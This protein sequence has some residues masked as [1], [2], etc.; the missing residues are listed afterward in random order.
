MAILTV[1]SNKGTYRLE[2]LDCASCAGKI[3]DR[4]RRELDP[5]ANISFATL[6]LTI[7]AKHE[8]AAK[9]IIKS[10]EPGI[11]VLDAKTGNFTAKAVEGCE[12][13]HCHDHDHSHGHTHRGTIDLWPLVGA[14]L[15]FV[16]GLIFQRR[17]AQTTYG[18]GEYLVFIP[19]YLLVGRGVI[20]A[21]VRNALRGQIFDENF[22]MTVATIGAFAIGNFPEAVGVMLF[23]YVGELLQD[24]AV[25]RSR[26]S[27]QEL[28]DIRPDI[29]HLMRGADSVDVNPSEVQIGDTILVRPGERI[30][31]D[32]KVLEGESFVDTSALTGESVP[33]RTEPGQEVL[34]GMVNG[35]GVLQIQVTKAYGETALARILELVENAASR[36]APTEQFITKFARYYTPAVVFSAAMIAIVPPLVVPGALFADWLHR[37][38]VLLVISCPCALVISIPLGYFGGIGGASRRGILVKGANHLEALADVD[39]VVFDKT[40]TLTEGVFQVQEITTAEGFAEEDVLRLAA[41][42]EIYSSHPIALSILQ[43][44]QESG[45]YTAQVSIPEGE[46]Q[47]I[48]GKGLK[49]LVDD[50]ELLV[51]NDK[52]LKDHGVSFNIS[53]HNGTTMVH[54]AKNR[55]Y[56]GSIAIS[57]SIKKDAPSALHNLWHLGVKETAMLSGDTQ[58]SAHR[59][60][61]GLGL[62]S[63][64][65]ELLPHDK[66]TQMERLLSEKRSR[67]KLAFVGDGINDAPVLTRADVGIAMG[68]L[69]SDAAIEAADVVI[70][71]DK[72]EKVGEAITMARYTR[73]VIIQN[74]AMA[75]GVKAIFIAL[76]VVGAASLWEAV[77]AD[78]GVA[79]LA[80][81]NSSRALRFKPK[82]QLQCDAACEYLGQSRQSEIF[83][84]SS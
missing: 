47:E 69:G 37:A 56:A 62:K 32:G 13:G 48:A 21:A 68:G 84:A 83:G 46:F 24:K 42:A 76:G 78:V 18:I 26:G 77:F 17:L 41:Q 49:V 61:N 33:Q 5:E 73:R 14:G 79:I 75:F 72:L 54:V 8:T 11:V 15:L 23:Y 27:I 80:V 45:T 58:A 43:A 25:A 4:L 82:T 3:E 29:A 7:D 31:L 44:A 53:A 55:Q 30:P 16:F 39:T 12:H 51:G 20:A 60:G 64:Y 81:L 6:T 66:V 38:L 9:E 52:L 70:M 1:S 35:S 63:I 50:G 74:I 2:G 34:A 22:L 10:I 40:G 67:G 65:A 28:L 71:E 57:D 59:V 19:A 36:K